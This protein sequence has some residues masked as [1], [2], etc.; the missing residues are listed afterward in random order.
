[1]VVK[2]GRELAIEGLLGS[3]IGEIGEREGDSY[4]EICC[5]FG[6]NSTEKNAWA[7][8]RDCVWFVE[9]VVG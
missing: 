2:T 8:E 3:R 6:R 5:M 9:V 4:R 7:T 1:M